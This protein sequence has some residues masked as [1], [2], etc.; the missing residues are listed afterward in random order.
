LATTTSTGAWAD[1]TNTGVQP[2]VGLTPYNGNL[3]INTPGAVVSGLD[4]NGT[5][6][7]NAANV[8]LVNCKVT[9]SSFYVVSITDAGAGA[10]VQNCTIDGVGTGNS[11]SVGINGAGTFL[12]NNIFNVEDGIHPGSNSTIQG[13][14]IHGLRASDNAWG[15]PHYDGIALDGGQSNVSIRHNTIINSW[16]Q[17][18]AIMIDNWAGPISNIEVHDNLLFGGGYTVYVDGRFNEKLISNVAIKNN[19]FG[20]GRYGHVYFS[21][22]PVFTENVYDSAAIVRSMGLLR[23]QTR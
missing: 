19:H 15:A 22:R 6:T 10:T 8:T 17:T 1:A 16:P 14:Y 4:I 13:N 23:Q 21:K 20:G 2:G 7:I 3:V 12:N 18:S 9:S 11:G 5:V